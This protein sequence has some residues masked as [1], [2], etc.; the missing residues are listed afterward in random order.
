M[1][2]TG[3]ADYEAAFRDAEEQYPWC[4]R[5]YVGFNEALARKIMAAADMLLMPSRCV[6]GGR[7][8]CCGAAR[9]PWEAA[10][11]QP[12]VPCMS[13]HAGAHSVLMLLPPPCLSA[14]RFEPCGLNQQ[15]AMR[16][17]TVPIV[18]ATGGLVDTV[19]DFN[20]FSRGKQAA[21]AAC[22]A[23]S[24]CTLSAAWRP[25]RQ[26]W[27][28]IGCATACCVQALVPPTLC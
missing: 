17:G 15:Y 16:Y 10:S 9:A 5:A 11:L 26:L 18:H 8:L 7:V 25:A 3:A 14:L 23:C 2:G 1:L 24:C 22:P 6:V 28:A 21:W 12:H 19:E 13:I 20:P 27:P 4:V